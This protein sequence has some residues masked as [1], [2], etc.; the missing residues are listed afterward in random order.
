[1]PF[2]RIPHYLKKKT[3]VSIS[4][5]FFLILGK[6]FF[7]CS[8]VTSCSWHLTNL[9]PAFVNHNTVDLQQI[10]GNKDV[11]PI[12]DINQCHFHRAGSY[13]KLSSAFTLIHSGIIAK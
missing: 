12:T 11:Q 9:P 13:V 7:Q 8:P 4:L 3:R 1:M 10:I 2:K 6:Q 5:S